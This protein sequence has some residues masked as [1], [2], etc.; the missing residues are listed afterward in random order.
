MIRWGIRCFF[1][2]TLEWGESCY[3][4]RDCIL[5]KR[6]QEKQCDRTAEKCGETGNADKSRKQSIT[7]APALWGGGGWSHNHSAELSTEFASSTLWCI[8]RDTL[9]LGQLPL[10]TQTPMTVEQVE[11]CLAPRLQISLQP[12]VAPGTQRTEASKVDAVVAV[13]E[14]CFLI[15]VCTGTREDCSPWI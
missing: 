8:W 3:Q 1:H 14:I 15:S 13:M 2:V 9:R 4:K 7:P 12:A 6:G 10:G 5:K 11:R